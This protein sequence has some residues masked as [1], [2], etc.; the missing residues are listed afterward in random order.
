LLPVNHAA[1]EKLQN[2]LLE[3]EMEI[4]A[5]I[6]DRPNW[7]LSRQRFDRLFGR[8]KDPADEV[9]NAG[10]FSAFKQ[11]YFEQR[12]KDKGM[13][14]I[15]VRTVSAL[16]ASLK[17]NAKIM[18][19]QM[20]EAC[21]FFHAGHKVNFTEEELPDGYAA[22]KMVAGKTKGVFTYAEPT[23]ALYKKTSLTF[24]YWVPKM[25]E[26]TEEIRGKKL[27]DW[28]NEAVLEH[29]SC[30]DHM[31]ISLLFLSNPDKQVPIAKAEGRQALMSL[32]GEEFLWTKKSAKR[33][34]IPGNNARIL[35]GL[36]ELNRRS[37][38]S[39]PLEAWSRLQQAPFLKVLF[40]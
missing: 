37:G 13:S 17:N 20:A 35:A 7:E 6:P 29:E 38:T 14:N 23:P 10:N 39:I 18:F 27:P 8:M 34:D 19:L 32:L 33:E 15:V 1:M 25:L 28:K 9:W 21:C 3:N 40:K 5:L 16:P 30:T 12:D 22:I 26:W 11:V 2:A 31:R 36:N 24:D 4:Q